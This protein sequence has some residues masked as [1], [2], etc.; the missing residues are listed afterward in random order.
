ME[1]KLKHFKEEFY[2]NQDLYKNYENKVISQKTKLETK[3]NKQNARLQRMLSARNQEFEDR[4]AKQRKQFETKVLSKIEQLYKGR[5]ET[6]E[7]KI[8]KKIS[9]Y[10]EQM[11]K[12]ETKTAK[13]DKKLKEYEEKII[14][15]KMTKSYKYKH[16]KILKSNCKFNEKMSKLKEVLPEEIYKKINDY[17][18]KTF[19]YVKEDLES[20]NSVKDVELKKQETDY[21]KGIKKRF[22]VLNTVCFSILAFICLNTQEDIQETFTNFTVNNKTYV[23][24]L[25]IDEGI[26]YFNKDKY[27]KINTSIKNYKILQKFDN[28]FNMI[29]YR[30]NQV[31]DYYI[32]ESGYDLEC[33]NLNDKTYRKIL[34]QKMISSPLNIETYQYLKKLKTYL[35]KENMEKYDDLLKNYR[36]ILGNFKSIS[37]Y[38]VDSDSTL[39]E[40]YKIEK[41]QKILNN[42]NTQEELVHN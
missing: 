16:L 6:E 24:D 9:K 13:L 25:D 30:N 20:Y 8:N 29:F 35:Y 15:K 7:N 23:N 21:S 39:E 41:E 28:P 26:Y 40:S 18:N 42:L 19:E 33:F 10:E 1:S 17:Y 4:I 2:K 38:E 36:E 22:E 37:V 14:R 3:I 31:I 11:K 32:Y 12:I 27:I 34:T 5:I